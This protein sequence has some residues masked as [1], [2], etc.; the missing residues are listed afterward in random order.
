MTLYDIRVQL[1]EASPFQY[2]ILP[3]PIYEEGNDYNSVVNFT[4]CNHLWAIPT[5]SNDFE[6]AQ[7][8]MNIFAA[9]SNVEYTD[10]T[11]YAYYERTLYLNMATDAGSRQAMDIIKNSM[12]YD[13]ALL[14][15]WYGM[16][17]V[18]LGELT[19]DMQGTYAGNVTNQSK[20]N[21]LLQ[22]TVAKLKN[23]QMTQ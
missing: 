1:Y 21:Q 6:I 11:M 3:N 16:G 20:I 22:D 14:Y 2:G 17:T 8:M 7:K 4:N 13:I 19:V 15:D 12:V 5:L 23:P 9:Y 10:S 18:T